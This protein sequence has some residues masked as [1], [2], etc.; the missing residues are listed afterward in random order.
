MKWRWFEKYWR[1]KPEWITD[2]R[3]SI[4]ELWSQYKDKPTTF[5]ASTVT[6]I[7][8]I[9]QDEWSLL[10]TDDLDQLQL[11]EL[12][13]YTE[14]YSAFDSPIPY[15]LNKRAVWLQLA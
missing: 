8:M 10:G 6:P 15:W 13:P 7:P 3:G 1:S 14:D 11:Y 4:T 9:P 2:A 12:E 5:A